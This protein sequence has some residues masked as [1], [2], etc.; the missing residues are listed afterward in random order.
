MGCGIWDFEGGGGG[1]DGGCDVGDWLLR[2]DFR[3][4]QWVLVRQWT[5][6]RTRI[7]SFLVFHYIVP[8]YYIRI[9]AYVLTSQQ[10]HYFT[11]KNQNELYSYTGG[12]RN[13]IQGKAKFLD[14]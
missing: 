14:L 11:W 12:A 6:T 1:G 7:A 9:Y 3:W 2:V 8:S 10:E 4:P 13:L 5:T